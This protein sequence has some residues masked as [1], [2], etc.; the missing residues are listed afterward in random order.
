MGFSGDT[1]VSPATEGA[2]SKLRRSGG[3]GDADQTPVELAALTGS[4]DDGTIASMDL[5]SGSSA[6]VEAGTLALQPT[7][8]QDI[9]TRPDAASTGKTVLE[10]CGPVVSQA[11]PAAATPE[12]PEGAITVSAPVIAALLRQH[13]D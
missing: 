6:M 11:E 5:S 7:G 1:A 9:A 3:L 4:A 10:S 12:R 13:A 8:P 2:N